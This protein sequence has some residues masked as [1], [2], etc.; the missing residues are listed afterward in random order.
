MYDKMKKPNPFARRGKLVSRS[1]ISHV[2]YVLLKAVPSAWVHGSPT[3]QV[4]NNLAPQSREDWLEPSAIILAQTSATI[5][6]DAAQGGGNKV[7]FKTGEYDGSAFDEMTK[8]VAQIFPSVKA[9]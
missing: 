4:D 3:E 6:N 9:R 1:Y 7:C 2:H 5:M 8:P